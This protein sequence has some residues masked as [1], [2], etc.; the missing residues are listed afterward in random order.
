MDTTAPCAHTRRQRRVRRVGRAASALRAVALL[1]TVG[2]LTT[3]CSH[4][5]SDP[6]VASGASSS[7]NAASAPSSSP[8]AGPLAFAECVRA[9]GVQDFPDPDSDGNFDLSRGGDLNPT[10][11]TYQA[12]A[13]ACRSY[14]SAGKGSA[15]AL[16]PQQIAATLKFAQCMREN[17]ITNYPDPDSSGHIPGVR[18]F[19]VDPNSPQFQP[20][21]NACNHYMR[22]IPGWS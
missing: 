12:A 2:V 17:G 8:P 18:H 14:E 3:A 6:G 1:T 5:A 9:H 7:A 20:A 10:N 11:P 22:A 19:G 13:Q 15:P 16:S 21:V 4:N